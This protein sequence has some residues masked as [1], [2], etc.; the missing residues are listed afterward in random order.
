[1]LPYLILRAKLHP[2]S[3]LNLQTT[4]CD[5]RIVE[6]PDTESWLRIVDDMLALAILI[7]VFAFNQL[8]VLLFKKTNTTWQYELGLSLPSIPNL[9]FTIYIALPLSTRERSCSLLPGEI[10]CKL[11][12]IHV[13]STSCST[14]LTELP[15]KEPSFQR[16]AQLGGGFINNSN[17][18]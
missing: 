1:M 17:L 2:T 7:R 6:W 18:E 14:V 10:L 9:K 13:I 5:F 3:I 4:I 12:H 8:I 15:S 16:P 11:G